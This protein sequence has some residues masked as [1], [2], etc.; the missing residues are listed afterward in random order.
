MRSALPLFAV[1]ALLSAAFLLPGGGAPALG[2]ARAAEL[3]IEADNFYFCDSSFQG[4]VCE[5]TVNAGDTVTWKIEHGTHT[6][7]QCDESLSTCPPPGGFNSGTL[8]SGQ[9]FSRVFDTPG[10]FFYRCNLHPSQMRGRVVVL[11]QTTATPT[12]AA[13]ATP[14][15]AATATPMRFPSSCPSQERIS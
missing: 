6:V 9:E 5:K 8:S 14:A 13:T 15:P 7:T 1:G 3:E 2:R 4:G 12:P 10:T 11:A